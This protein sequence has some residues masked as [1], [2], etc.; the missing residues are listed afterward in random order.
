[1]Q[2]SLNNTMY[3]KT[4]HF[5]FQMGFYVVNIFLRN[6]FIHINSQY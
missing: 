5:T 1:M 2:I 6:T 3:Y 4:V